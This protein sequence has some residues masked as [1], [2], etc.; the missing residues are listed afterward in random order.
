VQGLNFVFHLFITHHTRLAL[1]QLVRLDRDYLN[2]NREN[3]RDNGDPDDPAAEDAE[4]LRSVLVVGRDHGDGVEEERDPTHG[5][6]THVESSLLNGHLVNSQGE[7]I[8]Q[9]MGSEGTDTAF[10]Q[11]RLAGFPLVNGNH[12]AR[13][14]THNLWVNLR[15]MDTCHIEG[16]ENSPVGQQM[17]KTALVNKQDQVWST[18]A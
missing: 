12:K 1:A 17:K 9:P 15:A 3:Q 14:M 18:M 8:V 13:L 4:S 11:K 2:T 7:G 10:S 5:Q 16:L 6:E